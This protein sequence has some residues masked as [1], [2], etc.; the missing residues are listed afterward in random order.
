[1]TFVADMIVPAHA[2][3]DLGQEA[4][5]SITFLRY[6]LELAYREPDDRLARGAL[7]IVSQRGIWFISPSATLPTSFP[8]LTAPGNGAIRS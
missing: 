7:T 2:I 6:S 8:F 5:A 1:M 3:D 4:K